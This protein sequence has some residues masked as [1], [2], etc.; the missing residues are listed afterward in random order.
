MRSRTTVKK[1]RHEMLIVP[2]QVISVGTQSRLDA[3]ILLRRY[4]VISHVSNFI[5]GLV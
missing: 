5:N 4:I 1:I 3:L 2:A